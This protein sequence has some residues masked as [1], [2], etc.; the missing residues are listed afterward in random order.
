MRRM[1]H[2]VAL[3]LMMAPAVHAQT[4]LRPLPPPPTDEIAIPAEE[5][6]LDSSID[7]GESQSLRVSTSSEP[8]ATAQPTK[9]VPVPAASPEL[10]PFGSDRPY[11]QLAAYMN[12]S[13]ASPNLWAG[14]ACERARIAACINR[15]VDH[16][17]DC[18]DKS[19]CLHKHASSGC[20]SDAGCGIKAAVHGKINRY[21]QPFS[22][23]YAA[24]SDS[25]GT[26]CQSADCS[27]PGG[28]GNAGCT[29]CQSA[30]NGPVAVPS[31]AQRTLPILMAIPSRNRTAVPEGLYSDASLPMAKSNP[32]FE[33]RR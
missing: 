18:S 29:S 19:R 13:D 20:S 30:Q 3:M 4:Q 28:C 12:C 16:Q 9:H 26:K 2:A 24:P 7:L 33:T 23:L 6:N 10:I 32:R 14:Y 5:T 25:C 21:K 8:P 1:M 17:C 27:S 11:S 31:S 15:H 22:T